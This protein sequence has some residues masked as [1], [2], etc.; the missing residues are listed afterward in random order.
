MAIVRQL[1]HDGH[2]FFWTQEAFESGSAIIGFYFGCTTGM[3]YEIHRKSL[4]GQYIALHYD[5]LKVAGEL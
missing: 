5:R 2:T 4:Y 3:P 1:H